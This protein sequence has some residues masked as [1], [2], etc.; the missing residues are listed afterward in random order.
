[1][2]DFVEPL[3]S[4]TSLYPVDSVVLENV[5]QQARS[6]VF[7]VCKV[8]SAEIRGSQPTIIKILENFN[9]IGPRRSADEIRAV[10]E[11]S[12]LAYRIFKN[13][14]KFNGEEVP[15]VPPDIADS[16]MGDYQSDDKLTRDKTGSFPVE[17]IFGHKI[18]TSQESLYNTLQ[19][20]TRIRPKDD[21]TYMR[22]KGAI[23]TAYIFKNLQDKI[24]FGRQIKI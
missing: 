11:G 19:F 21:M 15:I 8:E 16:V 2:V 5:E 23:V 24:D 7:E 4:K 17:L 1:M 3:S 14:T 12:A 22:L 13:Q 6:N 18:K 9:L 10:L 20:I